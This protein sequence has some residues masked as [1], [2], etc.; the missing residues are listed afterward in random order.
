[1]RLI[2]CA[3]ALAFW[4]ACWLWQLPRRAGWGIVGF[5]QHWEPCLNWSLFHYPSQF[6][7]SWRQPFL[8]HFWKTNMQ[9][10]SPN[11]K[12]PHR[13][14]RNIPVCWKG[15]YCAAEQ[16]WAADVAVLGCLFILGHSEFSHHPDCPRMSQWVRLFWLDELKYLRC[17][18]S[19]LKCFTHFTKSCMST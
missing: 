16:P 12:Q 18:K 3:T 13:S 6:S 10:K 14:R 7:G 4:A 5:L 9:T 11:T 8:S 17:W 15:K 2:L 19:I 1:M